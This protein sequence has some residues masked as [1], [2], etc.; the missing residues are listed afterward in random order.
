LQT[1]QEIS[2]DSI[3]KMKELV[4][5]GRKAGKVLPVEE[6]FIMYPV[7]DEAHAGK[8]EYWENKEN[9]V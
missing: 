8:R 7:E 3:R 1:N 9:F 2:P 4:A 5:L 6:A